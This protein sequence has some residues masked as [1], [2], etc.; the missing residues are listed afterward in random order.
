M[1]LVKQGY[2]IARRTYGKMVRAVDKGNSYIGKSLRTGGE[3][4]KDIKTLSHKYGG[5]SADKMFKALEA[6]QVGAITRDAMSVAKQFN[7]SLAKAIH[8]AP[9][10]TPRV[11][12]FMNA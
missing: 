8:P 10:Q 5:S 1:T 12:E 7:S 2:N 9:V 6:S 3:L 11:K 4:Y